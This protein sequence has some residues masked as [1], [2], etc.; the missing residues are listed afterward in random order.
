MLLAC[1]VLHNLCIAKGDFMPRKFDL[2]FDHMTNKHRDRA[3][4]RDILLLTNSN[5][6]NYEDIGIDHGIKIRNAITQFLW[7]EKTTLVKGVV[8]SF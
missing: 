6:P 5:Q 7:D 4:L 8:F 3:E 1:V 2:T